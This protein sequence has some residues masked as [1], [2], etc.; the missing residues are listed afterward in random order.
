VGSGS[1]IPADT[2]GAAHAAQIAAYRRMSGRERCAVVFRLNRLARRTAESGIRSRHPE[3]SDEQVRRGLL[4]L[5]FGDEVARGVW[6][7]EVLVDP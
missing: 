1:W 4:R 7:N 2:D 5:L 3:Y 6:P